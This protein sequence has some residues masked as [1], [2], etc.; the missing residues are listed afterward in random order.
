MSRLVSIRLLSLLVAPGPKDDKEH[1]T[2]TFEDEFGEHNLHFFGRADLSM[3]IDTAGRLSLIYGVDPSQSVVLAP[4][5]AGRG[6]TRLGE[7]GKD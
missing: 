1:V 4:P 7:P 3:T 5:N 2:L 6:F